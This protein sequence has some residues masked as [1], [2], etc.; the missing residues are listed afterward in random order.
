MGCF[1]KLEMVKE[2]WLVLYAGFAQND[3][4]SKFG[5]FLQNCQIRF[6]KFGEFDFIIPHSDLMYK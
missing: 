6:A 3:I 1:L 2:L 5:D 4:K